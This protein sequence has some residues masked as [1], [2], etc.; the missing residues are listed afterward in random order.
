MIIKQSLINYFINK[1][2]GLQVDYYNFIHINFELLLFINKHNMYSFISKHFDNNN[3][4]NN[5]VIII[6]H[7]PIFV[8]VYQNTNI[9]II[10]T[11]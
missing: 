5:H 8:V 11:S 9:L 4:I 7:Y 3:I 10:S 1:G 2:C 6:T